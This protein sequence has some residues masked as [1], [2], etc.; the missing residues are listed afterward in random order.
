MGSDLLLETYL[1][2]LRLPTVADNYRRFTQEAAQSNQPY[3]RYLLALLETEVHH[4]Q[5]NA[6]RK[7]I[8]QARFP[9][10]KTLDEFQFT[11]IPSLNRQAILEL[12]QSNYIQAK[13]NVVFLGP[14]GTGKTHLAVSLGLGLPPGESSP[15][16]HRCWPD[17]RAHRSPNPT[18]AEQAGSCPS[19]A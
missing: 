10:L 16:R 3:E 4:R 2:Q 13:E 11:A 9:V 7:R 14:T 19:Q 12:A 1:K 5:A 6:E 15:L 17:Q 8:L 18:P